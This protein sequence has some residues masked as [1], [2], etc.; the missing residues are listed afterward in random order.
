MK[1]TCAVDKIRKLKPDAVQNILNKDKRGR[2]LLL[3][4]RQSYEYE[5]GHIPSAMLVSL[6]E[7]EVRQKE[8]DRDKIIITYSR[9]GHISVAAA[10][11]LYRLGF[12]SLLH[13][14]GGISNWTHGIVTGFPETVVKSTE[15]TSSQVHKVYMEALAVEMGFKSPHHFNDNK[16]VGRAKK[17]I[18]N[19]LKKPKLLTKE[20]DLKNILMLSIKLKKAHKEFCIR[21]IDEARSSQI[22]ETFQTLLDAS[23]E[24]IQKLH[25]CASGLTGET[26]PPAFEELGHETVRVENTVKV[27][28]F[29]G[30]MYNEFTDEMELLETAVEKEYVYHDFFEQASVVVSNSDVKAMFQQLA[31][32]KENYAG[33]LLKNIAETVS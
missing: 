8:I 24:S 31:S 18:V 10:V 9:S 17:A 33:I 3:D 32:E 7:I 6:S 25:I 28:P 11:A 21:A 20:S 1:V 4:V 22:K 29:V 30:K 27:N 14:E 19:L 13:L 2:F 16:T 26:N 5:S 15:D 23:T 12:S